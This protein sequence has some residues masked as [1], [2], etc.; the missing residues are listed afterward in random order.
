MGP[1]NS[2]ER[3]HFQE[4][5]REQHFAANTL[6]SAD[7]GFVG[8]DLWKLISDEGHHFLIRVGANVT[9][10][11]KLGY[12]GRERN[13]LVY[14]WPDS[15]A[16]KKQ[17]PLVL[18]LIHLRGE[19]GDIYLLTNVLNIRHLS[20]SLASRL[21]KLRWG[22]E[23]QFRALKQTFGRRKLRSRTPDRAC[24]ELEWSL[25]G[26]WMIHLFAVKEQVSIGEPPSQTSAAMAL[27]VVRSVLFLWCEVP[28]EGADLTTLLQEAVVDC[29]QR[30]S[31]KQARYR[32]DKKD[33]PSAGKPKIEIASKKKK[34]QLQ[35]YRKQLTVAA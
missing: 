23:L 33:K 30:K 5:I 4:M 31:S 29:Y 35:R 20:D 21:Y 19:R 13:G 26:L 11:K 3:T 24:A 8:Y 25:L 9:L 16:R 34:E 32:P 18:R 22:I 27:Q 7:A 6:F 12:Y 2:S 15:A 14:V 17:P 1:S 10:L 28:E